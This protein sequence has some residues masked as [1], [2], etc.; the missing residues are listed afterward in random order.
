MDKYNVW[1][2]VDRQ[3]N[4]RVI[5]ARWVFT[6][7][8]DGQTGLPS[9]YKARWVAKGFSQFQGLDFNELFAS[10]AHKD[11]NQLFLSVVNHLDLECN[12]VDITAA[13]L[14]GN[15]EETIYLNPPEGSKIEQD[16]VL[17]LRVMWAMTT[18][19]QFIYLACQ[20]RLTS[21]IS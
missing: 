16:K 21:L 9:T 11:S 1:T 15:L 10:V 13:F 17:L 7:K 20:E 19:Y 5:G 18:C 4:M 14:N 3:P 6:R 2:V 12:Q 8:V